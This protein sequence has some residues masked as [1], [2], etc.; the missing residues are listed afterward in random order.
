MASQHAGLNGEADQNRLHWLARLSMNSRAR[1]GC[2]AHPA[3]APIQQPLTVPART[4]S[5]NG[6]PSRARLL[7][8]TSIAPNTRQG[9]ILYT[10]ENHT[11]PN[12]ALQRSQPA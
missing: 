1:S 5:G 8:S 10:T 9:I 2:L 7:I 4:E 12:A 6:A 3:N 11:S